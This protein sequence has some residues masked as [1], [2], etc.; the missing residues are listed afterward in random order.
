[1]NLAIVELQS[2]SKKAVAIVGLGFI[3][4]C[5]T[6][7]LALFQTK[8]CS[9]KRYPVDWLDPNGLINRILSVCESRKYQSLDIIWSA[10]K[11]GFASNDAQM[12][13]EYRFLKLACQPSKMRKLHRW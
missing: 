9:L 5:I 3:G 2:D 7:Y 13:Q 1:M 8:D 4:G 11:G 10:G 6:D 12:M